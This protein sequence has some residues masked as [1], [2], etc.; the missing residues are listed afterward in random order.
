MSRA[1]SHEVPLTSELRLK[2]WGGPDPEE[3]IAYSWTLPPAR[4]T[5]L[6]DYQIGYVI[7]DPLCPVSTDVKEVLINAIETLKKTGALWDEG[8]PPDVDPVKQSKTYRFLLDST[9][10]HKLRD[11]QLEALR[12]TILDPSPQSQLDDLLHSI[13][14]R[15][16]ELHKEP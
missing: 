11:D 16:T 13:V 6:S 1:L 7:D 4:G 8:W 2:F 9:F 5:R 10:A 3:I 15:A 14:S 12:Q